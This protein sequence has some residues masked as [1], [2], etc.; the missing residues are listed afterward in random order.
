MSFCE[1]HTNNFFRNLGD[2]RM[3]LAVFFIVVLIL[4]FFS[5]YIPSADAQT[6]CPETLTGL[7][8]PELEIARTT[9]EKEVIALEKEMQ[10]LQQE[11]G[12]KGRE[13]ASLN[14]DIS[15]LNL[16]IQQAK[17]SI[18]SSTAS[19]NNLVEDIGT[20]KK[21]IGNYSA[22]IERERESLAQLIRKTEEID[23]ITLTEV[24][25]SDKNLSQLF[26]DTD[27]FE[28]IMESID[29]SMKEIGVAKNATEAEKLS[30]EVKKTKESD[31][32][33]A[34]ELEKKRIEANEAEK[35]RLL[36]VT[37]GQE[38]AYQKDLKER[39]KRAAAIRATLF[40]LRDTGEI[41]F[42][43]ALDYANA[44]S[45]ATGIRPA[46]LLAIFQQ[47]SGFGKSQGS[48]YLKDQVTGSG[49]GK[50]TGTVFQDVMNPGRDVKPFLSLMEKL[51][52][53]PFITPV[54]CPQQA[55]YGG[56]MGAAQFIPSTW[57]LF[58]KRIASAFNVSVPDPWNARDAFMAAGLL[59]TD[60]G[61][62]ADSYN[63]ERDAACRYFSGRK[64]S[65][66][67]WAS[68]YGN[69][70]MKRAEV[71]QTTMIDLLSV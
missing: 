63:S 26:G 53:D 19:I 51:G 37:K 6:A 7:S 30:L 65:Q 38:A 36:K 18:R 11:I 59:L 70:V 22:K 44:V 45:K 43:R 54:S 62:R 21:I 20:K 64:C 57:V 3:N 68:T 55:G 31:L 40:A 33:H 28:Y 23:S 66:S 49:V 17:L 34:Q 39:Q 24:A 35:Q 14:G 16:K 50:N 13:K 42:G 2:Y 69:Q 48:C 46:F 52:R 15:L 27:S 32:R 8:G 58:E 4:A 67:S 25:V 5:T 12:Q 29:Q 1:V 61:A 60:N 10:I 47:E 71:I 41:P 9:C 56:A